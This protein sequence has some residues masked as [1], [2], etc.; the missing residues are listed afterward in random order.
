MCN[1]HKF[2]QS[3]KS[4]DSALS[5]SSPSSCSQTP[6]I[7]LDTCVCYKKNYLCAAEK[8]TDDD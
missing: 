1:K 8:V 7:P 4:N 6:D 2:I 5:G 3:D